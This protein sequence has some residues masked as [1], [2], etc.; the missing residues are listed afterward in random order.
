MAETQSP[1]HDPQA[2]DTDP[3]V[4]EKISRALAERRGD[5]C[6]PSKY[7]DPEAAARR[8]QEMMQQTAADAPDGPIAPDDIAGQDI[9]H[10]A[11]AEVTAGVGTGVAEMNPDAVG[12][13]SGLLDMSLLDDEQG[14][15]VGPMLPKQGGKTT[16]L[17]RIQ[18]PGGDQMFSDRPAHEQDGGLV[19]AATR[20]GPR[21]WFTAH[22][23]LAW[24]ALAL[25]TATLLITLVNQSWS[26]LIKLGVLTP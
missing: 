13:G 8:V 22:P 16:T 4:S 3:S 6:M 2:A 14:A 15:A 20:L 25:G 12:S 21:Q 1:S 10:P 23:P 9:A 24:G 11:F 26:L 18:L 7:A 17:Y 5:S 19:S